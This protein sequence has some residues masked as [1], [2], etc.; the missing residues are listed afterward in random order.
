MSWGKG[1]RLMYSGKHYVTYHKPHSLGLINI[2][3]IKYR[4]RL[5]SIKKDKTKISMSNEGRKYC[6]MLPLDLEIF[7]LSFLIESNLS[8]PSIA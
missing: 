6:R 4:L 5:L 1:S 7:V 8:R 2:I 3:F